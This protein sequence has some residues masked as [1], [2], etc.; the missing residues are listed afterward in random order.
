MYLGN[1][2]ADQAV[3]IGDGVV[4][5]DQLAADAVTS[6]KIEDNAVDTEHLADDAIEAAELASDAVV[7]AS[8]ASDAAIAASKLSGVITGTGALSA[9]DL[10]DIGNLSGTNSGDQ[11]LPTRD[12]LSIDTNDNVTFAGITG[13]SNFT[14]GQG[15]AFKLLKHT[16]TGSFNSNETKTLM[17]HSEME[18]TFKDGGVGLLALKSQFQDNAAHYEVG[19]IIFADNETGYHA[20][21]NSGT[22]NVWMSNDALVAQNDY[23]SGQGPAQFAVYQLVQ[24]Q[25]NA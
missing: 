17:S 8:V 11:T 13:T 4:D 2:P 20:M 25:R 5:T 1:A 3:Q 10:T 23:G 14:L 15:T 21:I 12:S 22:P 7:N 6:A 18:S 24:G 16:S 19:W 9:Q